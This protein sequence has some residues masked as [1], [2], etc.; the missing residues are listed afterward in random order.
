MH[1][2]D[3]GDI[4]G[5]VFHTIHGSF[6]DGHGI[7]TTVFLKGCPLRCLWCC[8]PEG[9]ESHPEIRLVASKCN[10]C[11]KC[12][13]VC[14]TNAISFDREQGKVDIRIDRKACTNCGKCIEVCFTGALG[15]FG[16]YVSVEEV[17]RAVKKDEQYYRR[18]GGGVTIGGGEPT[19]QPSFT[20]S[21]MKTGQEHGLHTAVDTC[22]YT[23]NDEGLRIL[24]EADLL[25]YDIKHMDPEAHFKNTGA[26]NNPVLANLERLS[27]LGK[28]IIIRMP[29]VPG[30]NDSME[31][32]R[33]TAV[34]LSKM[35]TIERVDLLSYHKYGIVKYVELGKLYKLD[36]K[37]P[38]EEYM[39]AI[40]RT[41]ESFGLRTQIGG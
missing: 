1:S 32:I 11:G 21:L 37:P 4:R 8:N 36:V 24:E 38:T 22:G 41:L 19:Y 18:S 29:V 25:L 3:I 9:Q 34:F 40:R 2:E 31:N 6:V 39:D 17:F 27:V 30:Y 13:E 16:K 5:V 12:L 20:Y 35:K 26:K 10:G 7:R 15:F 23:L 14:A 28:A 33:A